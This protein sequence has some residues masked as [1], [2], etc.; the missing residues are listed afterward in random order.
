M[1]K[2]LLL[3]AVLTSL[4]ASSA[5]AGDLAFSAGS[6]DLDDD[7]TAN[8]GLEYRGNAF[9]YDLEPMVGLQANVDGGVYGYAGLNY[10]WQFAEDWFLT[11]NA[12]VGLYEDNSSVDLGGAVQFRTG[13]ELSYAFEND[14]RL[15][16]AFHHISNAGIY[17]NNPGAEQV[18]LT[19]SIPVSF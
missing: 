9:W 5:L 2:S 4:M 10:D 11:P 1:K 7:N 3:S 19:Y 8:F 12:A 17:D 14:Y 18:M 15:G 16:L 13:I 6:F